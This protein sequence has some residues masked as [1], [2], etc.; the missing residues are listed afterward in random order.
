MDKYTTREARCVDGS[1]AYCAGPADTHVYTNGA[2]GRYHCGAYAVEI[3]GVS[4]DDL[5][6]IKK[7]VNEEHEYLMKYEAGRT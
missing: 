3:P 7:I 5:P 2:S 4:A 6:E 1:C